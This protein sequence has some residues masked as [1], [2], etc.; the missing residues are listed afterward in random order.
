MEATF[1]Q[2]YEF[3]VNRVPRLGDKIT[4]LCHHVL[5]WGFRPTLPSNM[6]PE[7]YQRPLLHWVGQRFSFGMVTGFDDGAYS[8]KKGRWSRNYN[9]WELMELVA[10]GS[11]LK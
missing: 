5:R 7:T 11:A 9:H 1:I 2:N 8:A 6:T 3:P 4:T 10:N